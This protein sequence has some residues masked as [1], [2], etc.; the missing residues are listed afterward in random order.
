MQRLGMNFQMPGHCTL[1]LRTGIDTRSA[2]F[3]LHRG[4]GVVLARINRHVRTYR[5]R[6]AVALS[7]RLSSENRQYSGALAQLPC[8]PAR[9]LHR[10]HVPAIPAAS[11]TGLTSG[12]TIDVQVGSAGGRC[13]HSHDHVPRIGRTDHHPFSK[14]G[15]ALIFRSACIIMP[16]P[17]GLQDL[18]ER[19]HA[20]S[21]GRNELRRSGKNLAKPS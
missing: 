12:P 18:L 8:R 15:R 19:N 14:P 9:R 5:K 4:D 20:L 17:R 16:I 13:R 10:T 11:R 6:H 1:G 7:V 3:G 2:R 21:N